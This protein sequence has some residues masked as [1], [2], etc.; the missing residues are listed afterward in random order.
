MARFSAV[1]DAC[2]MVP[3]SQADT[4]LRL[5]ESGLYRPIWS[6]LILEE[7]RRALEKVHPDMKETGAARRRVNVMNE[8]FVDACV[9]GWEPLVQAIDLPDENDRHVVAA[10]ILGRADI[11]VTANVKDFPE[12]ELKRFQLSVQTPDEFLLNQL[13]LNA[14]LVMDVL[15]GQ[16]EDMINPPRTV[17]DIISSLEKAGAKNFATYA[18]R[19][20]WRASP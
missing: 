8:V 16:A 2:A 12:R 1:L 7:T 15:R 6:S 18:R 17:E 20:I 14:S 3:I 10:A 9:R 11:I 19:Q 13:D 4:L 5:A